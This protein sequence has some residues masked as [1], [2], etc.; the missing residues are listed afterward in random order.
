[1]GQADY[2]VGHNMRPFDWKLVSGRFITLGWDAPPDA[3]IVDTLSL[4]RRRFRVKSHALDSWEKR[5]GYAGKHEMHKE[6][7]IRCLNG[8]TKALDKMHR[9]CRDDVRKG[10]KVTRDFQRYIEQA[11]NKLLFR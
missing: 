11:T 3:K 7:W 2:L 10:A 9:Y 4:S 1:M 5:L 8:D 6:D